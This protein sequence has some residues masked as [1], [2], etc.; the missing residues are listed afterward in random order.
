M[1]VRQM[2]LE[3]LSEQEAAGQIYMMDIDGLIT[4]SRAST[5]RHSIF[6]KNMRETRSLIKVL[7]TPFIGFVYFRS[8]ILGSLCTLRIT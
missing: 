3:G 5:A 6:A 2:L 4:K 7:R 1:C 8:T